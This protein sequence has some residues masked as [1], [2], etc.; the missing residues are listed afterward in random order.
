LRELQAV[1]ERLAEQLQRAVAIDDP[2]IHLLAHTAHDDKVDE[3][4]IQSVM[5]LQVSSEV[6]DYILGLGI[7]SA[8]K[9]VRVPPRPDLK[10]LGRLCVPIRCQD[11]LL[12]YLWLIDDDETLTGA[13]IEESTRAAD[14]AGVILFRQRMLDDL[15]QAQERQ[16]LLSLISSED[17]L[18]APATPADLDDVG[19]TVQLACRVVIVSATWADPPADAEVAAVSLDSVVRRALRRI[20]QVQ[21]LVA[22][23]RDGLAYAL[24][25][26]RP[27]ED[28]HR[29]LVEAG[30]SIHHDLV[31]RLDGG[32]EVLVGVGPKVESVMD[33]RLSFRGAQ[34]VIEICRS[35]RDFAPVAAWDDLGIY[36]LLQRL[37][38]SELSDVAI[39]PGLRNLLDTPTERWLL[40]TLETYLDAAGNVQ[41]SAKLLHVHRGTLY[42]RLSRVEE[43]TGMSL[44]DGQDRLAL[45]L[46]VKLAR[47]TGMVE[48]SGDEGQP[49][50]LPGEPAFTGR[51]LE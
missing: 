26:F 21:I 4:R 8:T 10:M 31:T 23:R 40:A 47:L 43:L 36:R 9:P 29:E 48:Q 34:G 1:I 6:T 20:K 27:F 44:A 17:G 28:P 37:P 32:P 11:L 39:P 51:R 13:E 22:A 16:V 7:R 3:L 30:A 12:G 45:H 18:L 24:V 38:V 49:I 35:V 5:T 14:A 50:T 33:A 15:R 25:A 41:E 19:L 42:Y 2:S 46:G